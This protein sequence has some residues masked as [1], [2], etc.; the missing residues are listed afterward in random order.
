MLKLILFCAFNV[1]FCHFYI[2][3]HVRMYS[4]IRNSHICFICVFYVQVLHL[5]WIDA[6]SGIIFTAYFHV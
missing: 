4:D 2:R 6:F 1:Y 3:A 5:F